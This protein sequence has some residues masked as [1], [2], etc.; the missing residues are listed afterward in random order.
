MKRAT[1]KSAP[2]KAKPA[3]KP[4][5]KTHRLK[6]WPETFD[7]MA[8]ECKCRVDIRLDDRNFVAGDF[9]EYVRWDWGAGKETGETLRFRIAYVQ[10]NGKW[11]AGDRLP[12]S[13]LRAGF[14]VL[15]LEPLTI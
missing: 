3:P 4:Q 11:V 5:P 10:N 2:A 12:G 6:A 9:I 14:V 15:Q 13:G 8:D 1:K 7:P